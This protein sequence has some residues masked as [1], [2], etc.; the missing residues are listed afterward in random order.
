M[1]L[2]V[3]YISVLVQ[4]QFQPLCWKETSSVFG[5]RVSSLIEALRRCSSS[6]LSMRENL[7]SKVSQQKQEKSSRQKMDL[8][9]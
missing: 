7:L 3:L 8:E 6:A 1:Q 2:W 9:L 4:V 5:V